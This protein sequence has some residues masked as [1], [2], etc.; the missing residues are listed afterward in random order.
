MVRSEYPDFWKWRE[1]EYSAFFANSAALLRPWLRKL[2]ILEADW[3]R[4]MDQAE[5][6]EDTKMKEHLAN[7]SMV[8]GYRGVE[9]YFE[10][11]HGHRASL[12]KV[13]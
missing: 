4:L 8:Y 1:Q 11:I 7:N 12:E 13:V 3:S 6:L 10:L 9:E 2:Y 5:D